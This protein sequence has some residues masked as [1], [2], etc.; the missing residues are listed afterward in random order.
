[1]QG[2]AEL[3]RRIITATVVDGWDSPSGRAQYMPAIIELHEAGAQVSRATSGGA[4]SHL[5]AG[6]GLANGLAL[7]PEDV[8]RI[9]AGDLVTVMLTS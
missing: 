1:M 9:D 5:V 8:T 6:L 3:H 2:H 7:V 4:G